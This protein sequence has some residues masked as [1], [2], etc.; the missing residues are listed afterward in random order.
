MRRRPSILPVAA[1]LAA[2]L[3]AVL[4][5]RGARATVMIRASIEDL[6]RES[7][8]VALGEVIST[9]VVAAPAGG[10][11]TR[12][13]LAPEARWRDEPEARWRDA[14]E[15]RWR[16]RPPLAPQENVRFYVH[17]GRLG[18]RAM[19]THGQATFAVGER[20]VVFLHAPA[21]AAG[22]PTPMEPGALFPTG[23]SQG[24]WSV[25]GDLARSCA[26]LGALVERDR[27]GRLRPIAAPLDAISL[28]ALR[29]RVVAVP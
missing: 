24:K 9:E 15:A 21:S 28:E 13:T 14:Q 2:A 18:G 19:R 4:A 1:V 6:T 16:D 10:I 20:V 3:S 7:S 5:C 11:F 29:A 27:L 23:M 8:L 12:V 17:G 26:D 25:D 22:H